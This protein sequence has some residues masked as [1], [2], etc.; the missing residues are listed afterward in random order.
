MEIYS[1]FTP[2]FLCC[3]AKTWQI[4]QLYNTKLAKFCKLRDVIFSKT[5]DFSDAL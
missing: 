2:L 1:S 5:I 4:L 3:F